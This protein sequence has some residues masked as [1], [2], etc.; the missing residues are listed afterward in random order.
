LRES[1]KYPKQRAWTAG[2]WQSP[3]Q[4]KIYKKRKKQ[5]KKSK[6]L[7]KNLHFPTLF[8]KKGGAFLFETV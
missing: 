6:K 4:H 1:E 5:A 3:T 7:K 8:G 2:L